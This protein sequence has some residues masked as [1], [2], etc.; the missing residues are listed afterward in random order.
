MNL[1]STRAASVGSK[2]GALDEGFVRGRFPA[3]AASRRFPR[4][5]GGKPPQ[6]L[7]A[8]ARIG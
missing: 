5:G 2:Q 4:A 8:T 7:G 1:Q 3:E 6:P